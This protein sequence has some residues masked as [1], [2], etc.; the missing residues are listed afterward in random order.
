MEISAVSCDFFYVVVRCKKGGLL[1]QWYPYFYT[2]LT[3]HKYY[4]SFNIVA[5][6]F[7]KRC[8]KFMDDIVNYIIPRENMK[9]SREKFLHDRMFFLVILLVFTVQHKLTIQNLSLSN[10]KLKPGG[11]YFVKKL[12]YKILDF[13]STQYC[14]IKYSGLFCIQIKS[15]DNLL[16]DEII[17]QFVGVIL[18]GS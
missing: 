14:E 3:K 18:L 12:K 1:L 17:S 9:N 7:S 11:V 4:S 10:W 5:S 15:N 13:Y 16:F 8:G 2:L 6:L